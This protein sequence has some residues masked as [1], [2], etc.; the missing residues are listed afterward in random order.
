MCIR[1]RNVA[2]IGPAL[3]LFAL[4]YTTTASVALACIVATLGLQAV[5]VAGYHSYL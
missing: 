1:D 3:G 4:K 5:A 2:T